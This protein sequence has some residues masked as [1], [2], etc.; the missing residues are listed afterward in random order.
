MFDQ[1]FYRCW[2]P[3]WICGRKKGARDWLVN[4]ST[5]GARFHW[6]R[7]QPGC[8]QTAPPGSQNSPDI[9][10]T[11]AI[12]FWF[13]RS[14]NYCLF[15][16]FSILWHH[17][18]LRLERPSSGGI[19]LLFW[20]IP[21]ATPWFLLHTKN[22]EREFVGGF[23]EFR[24]QPKFS[25]LEDSDKFETQIFLCD[26]FPVGHHGLKFF[27]HKFPLRRSPSSAK[28]PSSFSSPM[29]H[30]VG[31]PVGMFACVDAECTRHY[32]IVR[33]TLHIGLPVLCSVASFPL[34]GRYASFSP[35]F[36]HRMKI[37][38]AAC[39]CFRVRLFGQAAADS[40][41]QPLFVMYFRITFSKLDARMFSYC[42][43]CVLHNTRKK[44]SYPKKLIPT[45]YT[46]LI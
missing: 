36:T 16:A 23:L 43:D 1:H 35:L 2:Q 41:S 7:T 37:S 18:Y 29:H 26:K 22:S 34:F 10:F 3:Y 45:I 39:Q 28:L 27:C 24:C 19:L 17:D 6:V 21:R 46:N 38:H 9:V 42:A 12:F 25:P 15:V 13:Q 11:F 8:T 14:K 40:G 31:Q 32:N 4:Q 44:H 20:E 33:T 30:D 5:C